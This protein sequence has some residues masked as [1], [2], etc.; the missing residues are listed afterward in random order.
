MAVDLI[1]MRLADMTRVHPEQITGRCALC[2]HEV[3]IYPSGQRVMRARPHVRVV[4]QVCMTPGKPQTLA[5]GAEYEP[6]Q[7]RVR[8]G[9]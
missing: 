1:T 4:C 7:S 9:K 6:M 8:H 5:P 3:G 2:Q